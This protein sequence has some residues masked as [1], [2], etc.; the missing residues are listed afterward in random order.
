MD[1][2]TSSDDSNHPIEFNIDVTGAR[3]TISALLTLR[4]FDVDK[5]DSEEDPVYFN[6]IHVG[7]LDS[8]DSAWSEPVF[9]VP[10]VIVQQG[11]NLFEIRVDED[12]VVEVDWGELVI[13]GAGEALKHPTKS[14]WTQATCLRAR[15]MCQLSLS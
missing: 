9:S 5:A 2:I 3:P 13:D 11:N 1:Q 14:P 7:T 6:G 10:I 15:S 12:R 8:V 4:V